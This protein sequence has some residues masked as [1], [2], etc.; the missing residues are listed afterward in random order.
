MDKNK[1]KLLTELSSNIRTRC[2]IT[3]DHLKMIADLLEEFTSSIHLN[4]QDTR[5]LFFF[6]SCLFQ[7]VKKKN[8]RYKFIPYINGHFPEMG[9]TETQKNVHVMK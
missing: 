2:K 6:I 4:E 3:A 9:K 7:N 1:E 5:E 8:T